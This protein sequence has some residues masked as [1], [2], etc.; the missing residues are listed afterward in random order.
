MSNDILKGLMKL[1]RENPELRKEVAPLMRKA[2]GLRWKS[3][4][5]PKALH[6][7]GEEFV[8]YEEGK[9]FGVW[10]L[11]KEHSVTHI[12][13]GLAAYLGDNV[14]DARS[15][16]EGLLAVEPELANVREIS[17][18]QG[19]YKSIFMD[20]RYTRNRP[21]LSPEVKIQNRA[22]QYEGPLPLKKKVQTQKPIS[23]AWRA[24]MDKLS[25]AT[26][27]PAVRP[28]TKKVV[29]ELNSANLIKTKRSREGLMIA[30]NSAGRKVYEQGY[31]L[32]T[33]YQE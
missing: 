17:K 2:A 32:V 14:K 16:V 8:V 15:F 5:V 1:G 6:D 33:T 23:D 18:L 19:E 25:V 21:K 12:P 10:G 24:A 22:F 3:G 27:V 26:W 31:T 7:F 4:L 30:L 29:A 28:L 11:T 20:M 13:S 9:T